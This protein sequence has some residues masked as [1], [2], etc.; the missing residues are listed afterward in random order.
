MGG[1]YYGYKFIKP[2]G[3]QAQRSRAINWLDDPKI[4]FK[5]DSHLNL[6]LLAYKDENS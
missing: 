5:D 4:Y 6:F 2:K 1:G 3:T